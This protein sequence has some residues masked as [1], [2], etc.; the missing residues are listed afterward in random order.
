MSDVSRSGP[1]SDPAATQTAENY[2]PQRRGPRLP[3]EFPVLI[4]Y[5]AENGEQSRKNGK[6]LSVSVN[7][8]LLAL[9]E[10][11]AIGQPLVLT[12]AKTGKE[13][14]CI[15]RSIQQK[16]EVSHVGIEFAT[17]SPEFWE[18]SFPR[19]PGDPEPSEAPDFAQAPRRSGQNISR[20]ARTG[21]PATHPPG[22]TSASSDPAAQQPEP[23]K[24]KKLAI[25]LAA[26][27]VWAV[28]VVWI[29]WAAY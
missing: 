1:A 10:A 11:V 2:T 22:R 27:A 8:A 14:E 3:L 18:I 23:W 7:G 24:H 6:T 19:E 16:N 15:V 26:L 17:W 12:N 29:V 4:S 28:V 21:E 13:I 5:L 20:K 9:T 25:A